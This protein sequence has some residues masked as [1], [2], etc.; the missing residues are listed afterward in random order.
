[1]FAVISMYLLGLLVYLAVARIHTYTH[2]QC[3]WQETLD[4]AALGLIT[5]DLH[6]EKPGSWEPNL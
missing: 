1:M 3:C 4:T 2:I 5:T 6:W